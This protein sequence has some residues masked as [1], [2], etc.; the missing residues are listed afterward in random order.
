M[1]NRSNNSTRLE[2]ISKSY[3]DCETE[4]TG[5]TDIAMAASSCGAASA[6][7]VTEEIATFGLKLLVNVITN[8]KYCLP[9]AV[10]PTP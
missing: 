5:T 3:N 4:L 9:L 1:G 2:V 8:V 6:G 7:W 10:Q